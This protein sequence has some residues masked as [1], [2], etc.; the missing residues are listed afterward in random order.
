MFGFHKTYTR[1]LPLT[2]VLAM[3]LD[4]LYLPSSADPLNPIK[5]WALGFISIYCLFDLFG[6]TTAFKNIHSNRS[7]RAIYVLLFAFI[8]SMGLAL[9][10]T[11]V[12]LIG[13]IGFTGRNNGFLSY[14]FLAIIFLHTV[15]KF[16]M[17]NIR[18]LYFVICFFAGIFSLYGFLQHFHHDFLAWNNPNNPIILM[19]GNP[20]FAAALLGIFLT[21]MFAGTLTDIPISYRA[22]LVCEIVF[23]AIIIYWSQARQGLV[24]AAFGICVL[25]TAKVWQRSHRSAYSLLCAEL[26]AGIGVVLGMLQVGPLTRFFYKASINDRGYDWRAAWHMFIS[27]PWFGVGIDRYAGYFY[28]YRNERYP[29]IYGYQQTVNNSH[30]IFLELL[31]TGGIFVALSY[32]GIVSFIAFRA[33][34]AW[35][36][37]TGTTQILVVGIIA[38]WLAFVA[39]SIISVDNLALS[40]WG[41]F[42]G[43]VIVA[44]SLEKFGTPTNEN[45]KT[46]KS[47]FLSTK[48]VGALGIALLFTVMIVLPMYKAESRMFHFRNLV[49]PLPN[50][51]VQDKS[52]NQV[53]DTVFNTPMMNPDYKVYIAFALTNA[54]LIDQG[55][56]YFRKI[57]DIDP[58][59]SDVNQFLATISEHKKDYPTA[60]S[61]RLKAQSI[62]PY[63]ANNLILLEKDYLLNGDI[64]HA[65]QIRDL[66]IK[67]APRTDVASQAS[68]LLPTH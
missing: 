23:V 20:D 27:H 54:G 44:I 51:I 8:I 38:G 30:N 37:Y 33:V 67:I 31:S 55:E 26:L 66:I 47:N 65:R 43:G 41:W 24:A 21:I 59:R 14:L 40:I 45:S 10:K 12:K 50:S 46:I 16:Q 19:L 9:L 18:G 2:A 49:P 68:A 39:Q 36:K 28:K 17:L 32:L 25:I 42:L 63:G 60:I 58:R 11:D 6:S 34:V 3:L 64:Q 57:L 52:Y 48:K 4:M 62:N 15:F 61:Y 13:V 56:Q 29:L 7:L 22:V 35:K 1:G 53:A 5:F